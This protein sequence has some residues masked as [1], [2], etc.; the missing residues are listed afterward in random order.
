MLEVGT[1]QARLCPPYVSSFLAID[2]AWSV[3]IPRH[4]D[5]A[6]DVVIARGEL[7]AGAGGVLADGEAVELLPWR[8][9]GGM[10]EAALGLQLGV[11]LL[12]LVVGDQD[13]GGTLVEVDPDLVAGLENGEPAVG[14]GFR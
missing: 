2:G 1:A 7:H 3:I 12:H 11:A 9:V 5:L 4:P 13:V 6:G 8:L 10:R 14:G